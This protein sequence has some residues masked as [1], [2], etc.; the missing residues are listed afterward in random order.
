MNLMSYN[1]INNCNMNKINN[2]VCVEC[3]MQL[4]ALHDHT[5]MHEL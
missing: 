1:I 4:T 2:I 3:N 5:C